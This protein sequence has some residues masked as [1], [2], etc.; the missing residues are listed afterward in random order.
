MLPELHAVFTALAHIL[1]LIFIYIFTLII[2]LSLILILILILSLIL[3]LILILSLILILIL[4]FFCFRLL[5]FAFICF[6]L[7]LFA[8]SSEVK[9]GVPQY[10][11]IITSLIIGL[12]RDLF[13]CQTIEYQKMFTICL[14]LSLP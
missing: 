13:Q 1:I 3:I 2:I 5:L 4:S 14:H 9:S 12:F 8:F 7:L 6:I 10:T 11:A